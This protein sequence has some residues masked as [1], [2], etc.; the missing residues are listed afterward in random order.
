[1][2][3][4]PTITYALR[5]GPTLFWLLLLSSVLGCCHSYSSMEGLDQR[6]LPPAGQE[7]TLAS[8]RSLAGGGEH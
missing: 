8:Q 4:R 2:S 1:M 3:T 7:T 6:I 5:V